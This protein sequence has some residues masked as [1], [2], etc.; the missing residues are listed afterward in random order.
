MQ[1]DVLTYIVKNEE[2]DE[3][4]SRARCRGGNAE[5]PCLLW[6]CLPPGTSMGS[7]SNQK[8]LLSRFLKGII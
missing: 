8:A 4:M 6:L 1:H 5:L 2:S 3:E 7:F